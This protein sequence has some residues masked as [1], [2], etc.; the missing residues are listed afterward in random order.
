M[1]GIPTYLVLSFIWFFS[2]ALWIPVILYLKTRDSAQGT[3]STTM[4]GIEEIEL[5]DCS[6]T[7]TPTLIVPHTILVYY[8]PM[9][10]IFLFY[11]KTIHI[12]NQKVKKRRSST[13]SLKYININIPQHV[14]EGPSKEFDDEEEIER[15]KI[16]TLNSFINSQPLVSSMEINNS[17]KA[18]RG[19]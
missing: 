11:S 18:F 7:A 19:K 1:T 5:A 17:S 15:K 8:L 4:I 12:V 10:L 2:M 14:S 13:V 3:N 9:C 6:I 16:T